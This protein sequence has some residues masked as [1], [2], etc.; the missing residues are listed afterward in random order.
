[1]K[2]WFFHGFAC[3]ANTEFEGHVH[4]ML[5]AKIL[6]VSQNLLMALWILLM[7]KYINCFQLCIYETL[8]LVCWTIS[9]SIFFAGFFVYEVVNLTTPSLLNDFALPLPLV[10]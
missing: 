9:P 2:N 4:K 3:K 6:L 10:L 8:F 7:L 5:C 1:M